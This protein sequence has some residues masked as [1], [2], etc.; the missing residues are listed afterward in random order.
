MHN[1][2]FACLF[3]TGLVLTSSPM[4]LAV[5][6]DNQKQPTKQAACAPVLN[7]NVRQ[8]ASD[9]VDNLC[10][11]YQGQVL[12][13]VNTASRCGYTGQ[14]EQLE[15]MYAQYKDQGFAVL[16]FPSNDFAGQEPGTEQEIQSFC[17]LTYGVKFPMFE[18]TSVAA[19]KKD[20]HPLFKDLAQAT[21]QYPGW[22]FHK[23]LVD[24]H[25]NV[26]GSFKSGVKP[27]APEIVE[28]LEAALAEPAR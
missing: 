28:A 24:R 1:H 25:G 6:P 5:P 23:Y 2:F 11:S 16:G 13:I 27:N 18:K 4:A 21:G 19:S 15:A 9:T 22:N 3:V 12:L 14:Y 20:T 10:K 17:R 7:H 8:L 26:I